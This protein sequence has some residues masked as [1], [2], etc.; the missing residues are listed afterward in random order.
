[1]IGRSA[2]FAVAT[3]LAAAS[4]AS[5][6]ARPGAEAEALALEV[7]SLRAERDA[8][9][10]HVKLLERRAKQVKGEIPPDADGCADPAIGLKPYDL[11]RRQT[12]SAQ[13]DAAAMANAAPRSKRVFIH[14]SVREPGG[15]QL[16]RTVAQ[17]LSESGFTIPELRPVAAA[18]ETPSVR[19]FFEADRNASLAIKKAVTPLLGAE[20]SSKAPRVLD[21]RHY[22]PKPLDDT[23]ELWVTAAAS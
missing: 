14:Y 18:I 10:E 15:E 3:M 21:M 11:P 20:P 23:L 4:A 16:A 7:Q 19:F 5:S 1:M 17:R 12:A 9:V 13:D 6:A 22:E 2:V 8:L